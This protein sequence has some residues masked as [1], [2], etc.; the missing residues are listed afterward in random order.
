MKFTPELYDLLLITT[1][2]ALMWV[3]YVTARMLTF[4]VT[5]A[6]GHPGPG[7]PVDPPWVDRAKRAH[8]N[9]IE[10]LVVFAPVVLIGALVGISN[11]VTVTSARAYL[12]ARLLHYAIYTLGI[13]FIRTLAFLAGSC[14]TLAI[15]VVLIFSAT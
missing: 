14:A 5:A 12:V 3:P 13:P 2:T 8:V 1:A 15:A 9:A 7:Y 4:G 11:I 6:V 10:N